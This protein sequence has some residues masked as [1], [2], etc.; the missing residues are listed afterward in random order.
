[1]RS[2]RK[3]KATTLSPGRIRA[4]VSPTTVGAMNSSVSP[5]S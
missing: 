3:L 2:G 4:S 5:A 1:M